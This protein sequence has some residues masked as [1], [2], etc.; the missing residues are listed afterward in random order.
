MK[1]DLDAGSIY[2]PADLH[3]TTVLGCPVTSD[4]IKVAVQVS[5]RYIGS[6]SWR[7]SPP[8]NEMK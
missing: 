2:Q 5:S 8:G 4:F 1:Y 3:P 7:R 6:L